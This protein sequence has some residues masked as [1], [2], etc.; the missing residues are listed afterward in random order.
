MSEKE[1]YF[2]D[3]IDMHVHTDASDGALPLPKVIE[4]ARSVELNYIALTDHDN[5]VY[6]PENIRKC[7][8]QDPEFLVEEERAILRS[9]SLGVIQGIELTTKYGVTPQMPDGYSMHMVGLFTE[10]P[11]EDLMA[12]FNRI[13]NSRLERVLEMANK[14]NAER[15]PNPEGNI[16]YITPEEVK[17]LVGEGVASRLHLG[18]LLHEK[19]VGSS[20]MTARDELLRE[21]SKCYVSF[22][23]DIMPT[24]EGIEIIQK[25]TK[26][27]VYCSSSSY[28]KPRSESLE[29][30]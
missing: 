24:E 26:R 3:F 8:E 10:Y 11:P 21:G 13:K 5:A 6:S 12:R 1:D 19:G 28:F 14:V 20:P 23:Q 16:V 17:E 27:P 25:K 29:N 22:S 18:Y 15:I 9:G 4:A 30:S 2:V 7:N